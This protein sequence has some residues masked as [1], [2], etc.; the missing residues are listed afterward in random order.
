VPT[1]RRL[2]WLG[3]GC[4]A[5]AVINAFVLIRAEPD[6]VADLAPRLAE[7]DGVRE[8]H[9]VAGADADI[10]VIVTV[11]EHEDVARVVTEHI[12]REPGVLSTATMIAFRSFSQSDAADAF[13]DFG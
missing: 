5:A 1:V 9:S 3:A 10:V 4:Q 11:R 8:S 13:G 6:A 7:I 12:G 2:T